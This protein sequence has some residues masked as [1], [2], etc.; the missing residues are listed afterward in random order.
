M[1]QASSDRTVSEPPRQ[2]RPSGKTL[3]ILLVEGSPDD[4]RSLRATLAR[5]R[6]N[7]AEVVHAGSLGEAQ[8]R[9]ASERFDVIVVDVD[10]PD[11]AGPDTLG[12]V[13]AEAIHLPV[14]V[15]AR[16]DDGELA[17]R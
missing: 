5:A 7:R 6:D 9:L 13:L 4:V 14:I 17:A 8:A 10:P 15:L 16:H 3:R 2:G 1:P 11:G 12:S